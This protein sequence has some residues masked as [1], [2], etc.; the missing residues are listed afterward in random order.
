MTAEGRVPVD[1]G[2]SMKRVPDCRAA[3]YAWR[4]GVKFPQRRLIVLGG[5]RH[6]PPCLQTLR[7]IRERIP[8]LPAVLI[9]TAEMAGA[10]KKT[11]QSPTPPPL[12]VRDSIPES[13]VAV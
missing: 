8:D 10:E 5:G 2:G 3:K 4:F 11:E 13:L 7:R 1:D 12:L 9:A 6:V